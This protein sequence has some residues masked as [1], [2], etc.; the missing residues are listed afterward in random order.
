MTN[1]NYETLS[2]NKDWD[3]T[4]NPFNMLRWVVSLF[5]RN[6]DLTPSFCRH[7]VLRGILPRNLIIYTLTVSPAVCIHETSKYCALV[8]RNPENKSL[9]FEVCCKVKFS[10]Q[11]L[12]WFSIIATKIIC[13]GISAQNNYFSKH[14]VDIT[15]YRF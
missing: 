14:W 4:K 5:V 2:I 11:Q 3:S 1:R 7:L 9:L 10:I 13:T 12:L 8:T 6:L 15:N